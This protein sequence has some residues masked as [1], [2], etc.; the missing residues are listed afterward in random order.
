VAE[1]LSCFN[2]SL[3]GKCN[4]NC[5]HFN[6]YTL[7]FA[8]KTFSPAG[9]ILLAELAEEHWQDFA[10]VPASWD[11]ASSNQPVWVCVY[12]ASGDQALLLSRKCQLLQEEEKAEKKNVENTGEKPI[13][14]FTGR[15][16]LLLCSASS[17]C[18]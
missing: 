14:I 13:F 7:Q 11:P 9:L 6:V 17:V 18:K 3:K 8:A 15:I 5:V 16:L 12:T 1:L 10:A 4:P 2:V